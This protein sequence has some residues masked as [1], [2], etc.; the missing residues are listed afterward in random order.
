VSLTLK[1][2]PFC[3]AEAEQ[4]PVRDGTKT[5]CKRCSADVVAYNGPG[6]PGGR[7]RSA[8]Q[9]N[10]RQDSSSER[11]EGRPSPEDMACG[12]LPPRHD[13]QC[14]SAGPCLLPE[15]HDGPHVCDTRDGRRAW[16]SDDDCDCC[17]VTDPDRCITWT[18][19]ERA[20]GAPA[21]RCGA[22]SNPEDCGWPFCG[23]DPAAE[24]VLAAIQE[25]DM[26]IVTRSPPA[27]APEPVAV[28]AE[29][30]ARLIDP[31]AWEFYDRHKAD[32]S[33][34]AEIAIETKRSLVKADAILSRLSNRGL[35]G[36]P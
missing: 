30:V 9:W 1:P 14:V 4:H 2:C 6:D 8:E 11:A 10:R 33:M 26:E 34:K 19:P 24:K 31:K 36:R 28:S 23:C 5:C 16:Q 17:D 7:M 13:P 35:E 3:G 25:H 21:Y 18:A 20:E 12:V 29:E 27:P 22:I 15:H 32:P